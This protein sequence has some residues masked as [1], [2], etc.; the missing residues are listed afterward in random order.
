[1]TVSRER[2]LETLE[3]GWGRYVAAYDDLSVEVKSA[4]LRRQ[5]YQ[6]FADVLAHVMAWWNE[7]RLLITAYVNNPHYKP[8]ERD[9]DQF[10]AEA[11]KAYADKT[12]EDVRRAFEAARRSMIEFVL[13][14]PPDALESESVMGQLN[15]EVVGH[16]AEH[17]LAEY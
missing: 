10:N 3:W 11:V 16:L 8:G 9:V 5:G 7:G 13:G 4:Y 2:V 14:L 12:E 17:T 15:M 6:R 1:M